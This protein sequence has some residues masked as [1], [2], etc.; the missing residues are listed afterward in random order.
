MTAL[1]LAGRHALVTGAGRGIG[2]AIAARLA[3]EGARVTL[4]ARTQRQLDEVAA[5]LG[6]AAQSMCADITDAPALRSAFAAASE[7]F[8]AIDL[9]INNAGAAESAPMHRAPEE[10]WSRM[11]AVNLTATYDAMRAVLPAMLERRFGRIVNVASTAGV[12]GYPYVAAYCA[13]KHGVIGLTRA[14]ALEVAQRQITVNAVCPGYTDTDLVRDSVANIS[15]VTGRSAEEA[16]ATLTRQNP[17]GRLIQP[18]EVAHT[19]AWL[20]LPGSEA[21]TGQS[22]AI[23]GGEV[24]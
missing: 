18:T 17:Q 16:Q 23:A 12:R 21:I 15:R 1:P 14:V 11:L 8:G 7:R 10:L 4:I 19:V 6:S 20:C 2:A 9:L 5:R 13:A 22:I 3:A 24:M